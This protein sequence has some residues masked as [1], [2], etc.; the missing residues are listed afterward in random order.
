M[1]FPSTECSPELRPLVVVAESY[2][3]EGYTVREIGAA[4]AQA[5]VN[6]LSRNVQPRVIYV[7]SQGFAS[8][9]L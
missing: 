4:F 9:E 6:H 5:A 7:D 2:L 1:P 3:Q 8:F